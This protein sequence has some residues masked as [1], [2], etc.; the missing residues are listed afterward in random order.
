[1]AEDEVVLNEQ[2][3]PA[4][5]EAE[6]VEEE[7]DNDE[8]EDLLGSGRI[9]KRILIEGDPA[10]GRP[11]NGAQ[12][13][14]EFSVKFQDK[15][16]QPNQPLTFNVNENEVP[17]SIDL[18]VAVCNVGEECEVISDPEFAYGSTGRPDIGIP[19]N[20]A[21]AITIKVLSASEEPISASKLDFEERVKIGRRKKDRGNEWYTKENFQMAVQC[22]R[23]A[24]D[25]FDDERIDLEA[26]IDRFEL[27]QDLQEMLADRVKTFNNMAQC[28]IKIEAWDAALAS[29]RE[30][31]KVEPNNEKAL[32]RKAKILLE[33]IKTEEAMGVLRRI[34]RLYPDN[35]LAK[36]ELAKLTAKER[37]NKTAEQ[38]MVKKMLGLD[39]YEEERK[40][41]L[42]ANK[43]W[44]MK[45]V[46]LTSLAVAGFGVAVATALK[47]KWL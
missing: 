35:K 34:Q 14:I 45:S 31:L 40:A 6:T 16:C 18:V 17:L 25:Y 5:T 33:T 37:K 23:K 36:A 41:Q 1:M 39:K 7:E 9:R 42:E 27:P 2:N 44:W 12:V 19:P 4:K 15:L 22:Y 28:Q 20:A 13:D 24:T 10:K 29:V 43:S 38:K 8:W 30:V 32:Y 26:P 3:A 47:F 11:K 46:G 21:V